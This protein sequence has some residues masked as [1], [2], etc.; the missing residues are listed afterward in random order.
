M[1]ASTVAQPVTSEK[2]ERIIR[3]ISRATDA[4]AWLFC[5]FVQGRVLVELMK[6]SVLKYAHM[7]IRQKRS[8]PQKNHK[9]TLTELG[10]HT[11][12]DTRTIA[13]LQQEPIRLTEDTICAEAA[14]LARW[15]KD[16]ALRSGVTGRPIQLPI[17]GGEGTFAGL[18]LRLAGRGISPKAVLDRLA[19]Q[20]N[21]KVVGK[22][23]VQLVDANW[24]FFEEGEDEL[25]DI[26]ANSLVCLTKACMNN[27]ENRDNPDKK[28]IERRTLSFRIPAD[29]REEAERLLNKKILEQNLEAR[30]LMKSL[31]S[32]ENDSVN[33]DEVL[34]LGYYFWRDKFSD[35]LTSKL[36]SAM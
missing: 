19:A 12:L 9:I 33:S 34:G 3:A 6:R 31:E 20:G 18:V 17:H 4:I 7:D 35:S 14:I 8:G 28:W 29:K 21:V 24:N 10:L 32:S 30:A 23:W 15:A 22:H 11:G 2:S 16:P 1:K 25:L 26:A 13:A 5:R 36:D 27:V